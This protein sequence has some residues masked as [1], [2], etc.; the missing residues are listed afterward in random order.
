MLATVL[1]WLVLASVTGAIVG[2]GTSL[3]LH[4][5]FF[6]TDRTAMVP[7]WLQMLL[8]PAGGLLNGLL[9]H[10]G[11]RFDRTGLKDTV[12]AAVHTQAGRMPFL[13]MP[14]KPL[15]A[16]ITLASG[17]SA[18][19]E[20]PCSH[21][22]ASLAAAIGQV[23]HLNTELRQ[24]IVA[25]GVSAGFASVFGT[26]IAGAIYGVEVLAIGRIRHDFL[27]PAIVA[28]VVSYQV[29]LYWGVPYQYYHFTTLPEFS[30]LLFL[31]TLV[32]GALCGLVALVFVEF[33]HRTRGLFARLRARFDLWPPLMPLGGGVLLSLLILVIPT[34][35]LGLSLPLMDRALGG[36]PMPYLGF[37]WKSLLVAVTI[38]SGFYGGIVTPQFVI[39]TVAGNAFAHLFGLDPMLGAAVGLVGVVAS[40]SNTPVA[41]ILMG[42]E[43]FGGTIGTLYIAG[44][45]IAA[46]LMIGHRSIYPG[47]R[48]A[49]AKSSWMRVRPDTPVDAEKARLSYGLLRWWRQRLP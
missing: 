24:R 41:A 44:A 40:A 27:F 46:Y 6:M 21:I 30:E 3:F 8:L 4:G 12:M 49:Y 29:S 48:L 22:G 32:L 5:L 26:P 16:I 14:I 31:K 35:Y 36:E 33:V 25:C 10:Y 42:V 7:F 39:G 45:A 9:L 15:A 34:D 43:L 2:T 28:G 20:G 11:Y 13:T 1:Q 47:Q 18:G 38:G 17:G 19:K 23:L 37:L